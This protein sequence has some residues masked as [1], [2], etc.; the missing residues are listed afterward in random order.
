M[1][2]SGQVAGLP[3]EALREGGFPVSGLRSLVTGRW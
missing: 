3:A 1:E 2:I